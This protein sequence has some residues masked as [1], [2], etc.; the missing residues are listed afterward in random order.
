[1]LW[2]LFLVVV[3]F[4]LGQQE[5]EED[6][7]VAPPMQF[8]DMV[9][10]EIPR[11]YVAAKPH[12]DKKHYASHSIRQYL[13]RGLCLEI[14]PLHTPILPVTHKNSRFA[15][16][17]DQRSLRKKYKK[18]ANVKA[19]D[20]PV[21]HYVHD[22]GRRKFIETTRGQKFFLIIASHII[23]HVPDPISWFREVYEIMTPGALLRLVVPDR[24]FSYDFRRRPTNVP[25]LVG[26]FLE[27]RTRPPPAIIYEYRVLKKPSLPDTKVLWTNPPDP[28]HDILVEIHNAAIVEANRSTY[29]DVHCWAFTP[30]TF[31]KIVDFLNKVNLVPLH[32]RDGSLVPTLPLT[33]SFMLEMTRIKINDR[34]TNSNP[35]TYSH[36]KSTTT[37]NTNTVLPER[38]KNNKAFSLTSLKHNKTKTTLLKTKHYHNNVTTTTTT[39]TT[40]D[41]LRQQGNNV[42][43]LHSRRFTNGQHTIGQHT[44]YKHL[45]NPEPPPRQQRQQLQQQLQQQLDV[46]SAAGEAGLEGHV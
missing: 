5:E 37:T 26:A 35:F 17:M 2:L 19:N 31:V 34:T 14:G 4:S 16:I 9:L 20:I 27:K 3:G 8:A 40:T 33:N 32:I 44:I 29:A 25:D 45:N 18:A 30:N 15:D 6:S 43:M 36:Q 11:R 21:I 23:E 38:K 24:R 12:K 28:A 41:H 42:K 1:M 46:C 13:A 7:L 39:T 22:F 10:P